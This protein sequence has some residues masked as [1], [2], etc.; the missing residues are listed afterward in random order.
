MLTGPI[1][2][3]THNGKEIGNSMAC[4]IDL[5]ANQSRILL[6]QSKEPIRDVAKYIEQQRQSLENIQNSMFVDFKELRDAI[7]ALENDFNVVDTSMNKIYEE[8]T[9]PLKTV[10]QECIKLCNEL[11]T[12]PIN[13]RA[14]CLT[15]CSSL[16]TLTD[17][18]SP[19]KISD[20]FAGVTKDM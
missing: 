19:L 18:C 4:V 20:N 10:N 11:P 14:E 7:D 5:I 2:N 12:L 3:I 8:C 13:L 6:Q 17:I 9:S 16:N 15:Q 1:L